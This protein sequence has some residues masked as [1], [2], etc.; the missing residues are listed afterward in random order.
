MRSEQEC[1]IFIGRLKRQPLVGENVTWIGKTEEGEALTIFYQHGDRLLRVVVNG[2]EVW[3]GDLDVPDAG[4]GDITM[5]GNLPG[6][7]K[8]RRWAW[9]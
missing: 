5:K 6:W 1:V 3:R 7:I 4:M 9:K 8:I 2:T